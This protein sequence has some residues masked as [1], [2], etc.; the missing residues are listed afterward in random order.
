MSRGLAYEEELPLVYLEDSQTTN[1]LVGLPASLARL[2]EVFPDFQHAQQ[3]DGRR[4]SLPNRGRAF[5]LLWK[6]LYEREGS[7]RYSLTVHLGSSGA[8]DP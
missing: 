3:H 5:R 1:L 6:Q 4:K 7:G 8:P 2:F